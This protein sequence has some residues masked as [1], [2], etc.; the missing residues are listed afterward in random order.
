VSGGARGRRAA[1]TLAPEREVRLECV[2]ARGGERAPAE[3]EHVRD[4]AREVLRGAV[5]LVAPGGA[6]EDLEVPGHDWVQDD[7]RGR[8]DKCSHGV[9]GVA[10]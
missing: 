9:E 1:R 4:D 3:E 6:R 7:L 8:G 10:R 5:H 2:P